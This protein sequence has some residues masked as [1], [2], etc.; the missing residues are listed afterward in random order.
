MV[1]SLFH[2]WGDY[3]REYIIGSVYERGF[4][5]LDV[6]EFSEYLPRIQEILPHARRK[7]LNPPGQA[8]IVNPFPHP[9]SLDLAAI[10]SV[11]NVVGKASRYPHQDSQR[12]TFLDTSGKSVPYILWRHES[13]LGFTISGQEVTNKIKKIQNM[14]SL[15]TNYLSEGVHVAVCDVKEVEEILPNI[16]VMGYLVCKIQDPVGEIKLCERLG[17][18]FMSTILYKPASTS[19]FTTACYFIGLNRLETPDDAPNLDH[20]L[21]SRICDILDLQLTSLKRSLSPSFYGPDLFPEY[22]AS[23]CWCIPDSPIPS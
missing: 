1:D 7:G 21:V 20:Y 17:R 2:K 8:R 15:T 19:P 12:V 23:W 14:R 6:R 5:S 22:F 3:S 18:H 9:D 16:R 10:D 13:V 11:L 4:S